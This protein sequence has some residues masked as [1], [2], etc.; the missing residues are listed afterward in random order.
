MVTEAAKHDKSSQILQVVFQTN[1]DKGI[2][3]KISSQL[4]VTDVTNMVT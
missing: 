3:Q 2:L 1:S 4:H